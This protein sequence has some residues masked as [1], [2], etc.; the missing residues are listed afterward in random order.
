MVDKKT[1]EYVAHLARIAISEEEKQSL[2]PQLSKILEY[3]DILKR[4]DIDSV[5]PMAGLL[6]ENNVLRPDEAKK[7]DFW[8]D[9]L[10]NA[11]SCEN[12]HFRI[13]KV[14]E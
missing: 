5:E 12:N 4:V 11:P 9:I 6:T 2:A 13:P 3:I 8:Q 1:V 10:R 7:K 14:I